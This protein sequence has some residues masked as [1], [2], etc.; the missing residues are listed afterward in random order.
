[1][2]KGGKSAGFGRSAAAVIILIIIAVNVIGGNKTEIGKSTVNGRN[3]KIRFR[4][5][6]S[7]IQMRLAGRS[8]VGS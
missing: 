3:L 1:M 6:L 2:S 8:S 7:I 4:S 5:R